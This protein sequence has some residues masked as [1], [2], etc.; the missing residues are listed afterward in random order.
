MVGQPNPQQSPRSPGTYDDFPNRAGT[1][2]ELY[3]VYT[4]LSVQQ[5]PPHL[6][7]LR[8]ALQP[9]LQPQ[10]RPRCPHQLLKLLQLT[11]QHTT[12]H[13]IWQPCRHTQ[14]SKLCRQMCT[15]I[16]LLIPQYGQTQQTCAC[17]AQPC[18]HSCSLAACISCCSQTSSKLSPHVNGNHVHLTKNRT[19]CHGLCTTPVQQITLT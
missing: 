9:Q 19:P 13:I 14:W 11:F 15:H 1:C 18:S 2:R 8:A 6:S 10:Q 4:N 12:P 3:T 7:L 16:I 5:I 17:S